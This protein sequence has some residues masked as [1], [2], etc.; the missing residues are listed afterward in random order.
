MGKFILHKFYDEEEVDDWW[1]N[2]KII[3][4]EPATDLYTINYFHAEEDYAFQNEEDVDVYETLIIPMEEDYLN[5]EIK[6]L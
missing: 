2:G 5:N 3:S 6:F 1:E 4:Y